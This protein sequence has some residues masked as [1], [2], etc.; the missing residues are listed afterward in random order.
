MTEKKTY[1]KFPC[2]FPIKAMGI[3]D[4]SF[5]TTVFR[6]VRK[7]V[8]KSDTTTVK[9]RHSKGGKYLSVTITIHANSKKQLDSIYKDLTKHKKVLMA[10]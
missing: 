7:H 2:E 5:E 3:A 10:L 8:P 4:N 1:L 9:S 6:I